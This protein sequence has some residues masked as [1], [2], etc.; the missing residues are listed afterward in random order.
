MNASAS[1]EQILAAEHPRTLGA[2]LDLVMY[3]R[4][5]GRPEI[6]TILL[7]HFAQLAGVIFPEVHPTR[8]VCKHLV[9]LAE[10][11]FEEIL[12]LCVG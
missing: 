2:L 9:P 3:L 5:R 11:Q 6:S 7:R 10:D 12:G 1:I 8:Q 4:R